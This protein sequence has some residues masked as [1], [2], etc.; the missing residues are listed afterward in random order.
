MPVIMLCF[1]IFVLILKYKLY[2]AKREE[3]VR[4]ENL[5]QLEQ[6]A[7]L[8]IKKSLQSL[9][10]III[11]LSELPLQENTTSEIASCQNTIKSLSSQTI[12]NLSGMSNLELKLKYGAGNLDEL[13]EYEQNYL[14][15][16]RTLTDWGTQ[17]YE[18]RNY[19]D[20]ETVLDYA[21]SCQ[22][23]LRQ[24]YIIL[25]KIYLKQDNLEKV[26]ILAKKTENISSVLDLKKAIYDV[27]N[28]MD[29]EINSSFHNAI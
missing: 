9:P 18:Q 26:H 29:Y 23:D 5:R 19:K 2:M 15:L 1:I 22:S 17:L 14:L 21:V 20:A 4:E 6:R 12:C 27:I 7:S 25:T 10:K 11:P 13:L 3:Q 24:T 8:P 28:E 16:I